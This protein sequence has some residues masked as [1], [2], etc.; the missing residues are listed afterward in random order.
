MIEYSTST[1]AFGLTNLMV[2]V[3]V[4]VD[5]DSDDDDD[6]NYCVCICSGQCIAGGRI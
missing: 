3:V 6:D 4:F 1:P 5:G 2:I